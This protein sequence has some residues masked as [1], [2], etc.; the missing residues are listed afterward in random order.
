MTPGHQRGTNR[1][2]DQGEELE[3][4]GKAHPDGRYVGLPPA[5]GFTRF[6]CPECSMNF[7]TDAE[8]LGDHIMRHEPMYNKDYLFKPKQ[9]K[10]CNRWVDSDWYSR[11]WEF[12][13][14]LCKGAQPL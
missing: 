7:G 3:N 8:A 4:E 12:H 1:P 13:V 11:D 10:L 2:S 14:R 9:C 6:Q 5:I